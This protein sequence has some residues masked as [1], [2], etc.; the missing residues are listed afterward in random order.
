MS[1]RITPQD[2]A[3]FE[4]INKALDQTITKLEKVSEGIQG[5]IYGVKADSAQLT[6]QAKVLNLT[7]AAG[8]EE[9]SK[10][11]GKVDELARAYK[12]Y[13][14]TLAD[15][16]GQIEE[17]RVAT[18]TLNE[19]KKNEA[20]LALSAEGS[21][22][23]LAAQYNIIKLNLNA[24]SKAEREGTVEG[25]KLVKTANEIYQEMKRLQAETGKTALNVGN[26]SEAVAEATQNVGEMRKELMALRNTSFA[27]KTEEEIAGINKRIG[28]LVDSM[29]D[30]KAE[31][32][33]LGTEMSSLFVSNL[34]FISAGVEGLV[35]SLSLLGVE[36]ES[37]RNVESK[38]IQLIAVTQALSEIEDVLQKRTLQTTAARIQS[39]V[40]NAK[41][42]VVKW[43]NN[44]ATVAAAKA[45]DARA[46]A[47]TR[48]SLATRAAAAVQWLWNAALAAN[49]IGLVVVAVAALAAGLVYLTSR[50]GESAA[51]AKSL[52]AELT[53][54]QAA[55]ESNEE[56]RQFQLKL[57]DEYGKTEIEKTQLNKRLTN[58]RIK[59][60]EA[61]LSTLSKLTAIKGLDDEQAQRRTELN[62]ELLR[63]GDERILL[64]IRETTQ[65]KEAAEAA[66]KEA[67]ERAKAAKAERERLARE[68]AARLQ[69]K[70]DAV[71]KELEADK[72][73]QLAKF[74]SETDYGNKSTEYQRQRAIERFTIEQETNAAILAEQFKFQ[75]ISQKEYDAALL[76]Q[77]AALNEFTAKIQ[78][79]RQGEEPGRLPGVDLSN[80]AQDAALSKVKTI[81]DGLSKGARE[82]LEKELGT[83]PGTSFLG[84]IL[85]LDRGEETALKSSLDFAKQ[86]LNDYMQAVQRAADARVQASDR[87]VA[88]AENEYNRQVALSA[89]GEANTRQTAQTALDEAKKRQDEA[90]ENQRRVQRQQILLEGA[91]QASSLITAVAKVFKDVPFPLNIAASGLMIGSFLASKAAAIKA[92]K[93]EYSEGGYEFIEGG[94]HASGNDTDL[95]F[96]TRK[97]KRA[98]AQRGEFHGIV[99]HKQVPKY[100]D[101]LPT[102]IDSLNKGTF[103]E[104]FTQV[105]KSAAA[106]QFRLDGR[107]D[108]GKMETLLGQLVTN[109]TAKGATSFQQ[110]TPNVY[111]EVKGNLTRTVREG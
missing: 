34:K 90:L 2:I 15:N 108:T 5:A 41:D 102:I 92:T 33:A 52:S 40:I 99:N 23:R 70:Q 42:T 54:L 38:M 24:M 56:F 97:G 32:A 93:Q 48:G 14:K 76:S 3:D 49:P 8:R 47:T 1:N 7:T 68:A 74:D 28:D 111:R 45:E 11:A 83:Q 36:S 58:E 79:E 89:A 81:M 75:R 51:L 60:I 107:T 4:A 46:I 6:E 110:L 50:M 12:T 55:A 67:A 25:Q 87:S 57:A 85:G 66:A 59:D 26:Y 31:Q 96:S 65:Q 78:E 29:A 91:A 53:S 63:L 106:L 35:G 82:Q 18:R 44:V 98:F 84:K 9:N 27:G 43:A 71:L 100:K 61:E 20:R 88:A 103:Y 37:L 105:G 73:Y 22:N 19:L 77:R 30:L 95:G 17:L 104:T 21:Y 62:K 39:A 101:V 109:S 80:K 13:E 72:N 16:K 94:T 86:Q 10:A 69:E 64:G